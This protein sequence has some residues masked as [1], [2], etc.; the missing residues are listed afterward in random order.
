MKL[1][2]VSSKI[3]YT[4]TK[5][6]HSD[7]VESMLKVAKFNHGSAQ[8]RTQE[9]YFRI[10]KMVDYWLLKYQNYFAIL[11]IFDGIR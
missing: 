4:A 6:M 5:K 9:F 7:K 10:E 2:A 8:I 3:I 1:I 11:V